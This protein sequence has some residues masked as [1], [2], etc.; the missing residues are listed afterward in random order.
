[1]SPEN[2]KLDRVDD[3]EAAIERKRAMFAAKAEKKKKKLRES[4]GGK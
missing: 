1:L 4:H 3:L 2:A